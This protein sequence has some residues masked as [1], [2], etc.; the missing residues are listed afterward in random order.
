MRR[1]LACILACWGCID[2]PEFRFAE[3]ASVEAQPSDGGLPPD[4]GPSVDAGPAS[5]EG[6]YRTKLTNGANG[7]AAPTWTAG[8]TADV[9]IRFRREGEDRATADVEGLAA[10]YVRALV[11]DSAIPGTATDSA[12]LLSRTSTKKE[13]EGRCDFNWRVRIASS[14]EAG[15][16][17]GQITY[18]KVAVKE[19]KDCPAV[20]CT[21]VQS[22]TGTRD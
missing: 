21:S 10:L 15:T 7:C 8:A 20:L 17:A 22:M 1:A 2:A 5:F 12:V 18:E 3:T 13:R 11:G 16:S 9:T 4:A 19:D 14:F 6:T